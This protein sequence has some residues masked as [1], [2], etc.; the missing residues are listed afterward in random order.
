MFSYIQAAASVLTLEENFM[1][2]SPVGLAGLC[3]NCGTDDNVRWYDSAPEADTWGCTQC[4]STWMINIE[5]SDAARIVSMA[6][7]N[8]ANRL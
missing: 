7:V 2:F 8:S 1:S 6:G 5:Q 3:P 4:G